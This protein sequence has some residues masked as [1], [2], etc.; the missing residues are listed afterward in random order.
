MELLID[1]AHRITKPSYL[2]NTTTRDV[3]ACIHLYTSNHKAMAA[4]CTKPTL[5]EKFNGLVLY[6][7][8]STATLNNSQQFL[9]L[10]KALHKHNI[11]FQWGRPT[12]LIITHQGKKHVLHS[13][14]KGIQF[15][16][17]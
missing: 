4:A 2:P 13:L 6:A 15:L 3:L 16:K 8:L 9:T 7:D 11:T 17:E 14:D 5:S 1:R 12:K 10:T